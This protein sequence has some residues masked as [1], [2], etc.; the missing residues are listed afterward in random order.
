MLAKEKL[1]FAKMKTICELEERQGDNLGLDTRMTMSVPLLYSSLQLDIL[2][3]SLPQSTFSASK[4]MQALILRNVGEE[5]NL[6]VH[7]D[8]YSTGG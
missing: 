6:I 4:L 3:A 2:P 1:A 8:P 5:F 7:F